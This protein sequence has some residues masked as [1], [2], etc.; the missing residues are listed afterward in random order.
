LYYYW[1]SVGNI[2]ENGKKHGKNESCNCGHRYRVRILL[3]STCC[4]YLTIQFN[5]SPCMIAFLNCMDFN[6]SKYTII[7]RAICFQLPL[8]YFILAFSISIN[9]NFYEQNIN[10]VA[11]RFI[12]IWT[13]PL[14]DVDCP[15]AR[16]INFGILVHVIIFFNFTSQWKL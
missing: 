15:K 4:F 1:K 9:I 7:E 6:W 11:N 2:K 12:D 13:W 3:N 16:L 5:N 10:G 14:D 8:Y